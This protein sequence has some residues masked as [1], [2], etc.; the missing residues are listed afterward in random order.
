MATRGKL[1]L[2]AVLLVLVLLA[3]A[4]A[5]AEDVPTPTAPVDNCDPA[6]FASP[7]LVAPGGGAPVDTADPLFAWNYVNV[8]MR[9]TCEPEQFRV[10]VSPLQAMLQSL[11]EFD[12][13]PEMQASNG[14]PFLDD[15]ELYFWRVGILSEGQVI[16]WSPADYFTTDFSGACDTACS[17]RVPSAPQAL[18]PIDDAIVDDPAARLYWEYNDSHY[19]LPEMVFQV[20]VGAD[21]SFADKVLDEIVRGPWM[22]YVTRMPFLS[23]DCHHYYWRVYASTPAGIGPRSPVASFWTDFAGACVFATS[24]K[25]ANCRSGPGMDYPVVWHYAADETT[26]VLGRNEDGT[27]LFVERLDG[28][29]GCWIGADLVEQQGEAGSLTLAPYDPP[30]VSGAPPVIATAPPAGPAY[31]S[32]GDYPNYAVCTSDPM[33]FNCQW[34]TG[35]NLCIPK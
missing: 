32:C 24:N 1:H 34:D 10:Q 16:V 20:E 25:T 6:L 35:M 8:D 28:Y 9:L 23:E 14:Q 18:G 13:G 19:C 4:C 2:P 27:W 17:L 15:C 21:A 31:S 11:T 3:T 26:R 22:D 7:L 30:P 5:P 29:G 12:G 33:N